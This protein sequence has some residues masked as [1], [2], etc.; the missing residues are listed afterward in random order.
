[1]ITTTIAGLMIF[2]VVLVV[3]WSVLPRMGLR[4]LSRAA[5]ALCVA[6]LSVLGLAPQAGSSATGA[7][8]IPYAA[9]GIALPFVILIQ[10]LGVGMRRYN[11]AFPRRRERI[12]K[13]PKD[14]NC[15]R[16]TT[17]LS[18]SDRK[19]LF[20]DPADGSEFHR[21]TRASRHRPR[22]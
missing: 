16:A 1:M 11:A 8:L 2:L 12:D 6:T 7:I 15:D 4:G 22:R 13:A 10:L 9:L 18:R 19:A 20:D 21:L 5:L 3:T 14:K 17:S